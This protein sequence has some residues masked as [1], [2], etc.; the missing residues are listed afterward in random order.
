MGSAARVRLDLLLPVLSR[1]DAL[2]GMKGISSVSRDAATTEE[3]TCIKT[4]TKRSVCV[5]VHVCISLSMCA[6]PVYVCT[7][8]F[9]CA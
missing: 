9:M 6:L 1:P 5:P 3:P 4:T 7:S 2:P 8:L